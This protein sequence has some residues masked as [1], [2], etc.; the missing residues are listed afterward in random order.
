MVKYCCLF[1]L[2]LASWSF[3]QSAPIQAEA[4]P[5]GLG[6]QQLSEA[7]IQGFQNL[8]HQKLKDF[9]ELGQLIAAPDQ[10]APFQEQAREMI[11]DLVES[12]QT[13]LVIFNLEKSSFL[14]IQVSE[15]LQALASG[16]SAI[17]AIQWDIQQVESGAR[18]AGEVLRWSVLVG[19]KK[20][21]SDEVTL[22]QVQMKAVRG[23]QQIGGYGRISWQTFIEG[24]E[25]IP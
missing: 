2:G 6:E 10:P 9:E 3:G 1:F 25:L 7:Q 4:A 5:Y 18:Q 20:P 11:L 19:L 22:C 14:P 8:G 16:S 12:E 13:T 15:Y 21:N 17:R 23:F 24:M